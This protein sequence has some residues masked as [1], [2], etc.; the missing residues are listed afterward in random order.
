MPQSLGSKL[1]MMGLRETGLPVRCRQRRKLPRLPSLKRI[2]RLQRFVGFVAESLLIK[3]ARRRLCLEQA[4][5]RDTIAGKHDGSQKNERIQ[6]AK[7]GKSWQ[8][9]HTRHREF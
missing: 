2:K 6:F 3:A 8:S 4:Q 9:T 1:R 5:R 7:E